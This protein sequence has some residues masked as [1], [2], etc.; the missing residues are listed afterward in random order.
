VRLLAGEVDDERQR[1]SVLAGVVASD[2]TGVRWEFIGKPL[3]YPYRLRV[4]AEVDLNPEGVPCVSANCV[5]HGLTVPDATTQVTPH[6]TKWRFAQ[7]QSNF[8]AAHTT[9]KRHEINAGN[10]YRALDL[11]V[12]IAGDTVRTVKAPSGT[13]AT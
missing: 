5:A 2:Q 1:D 9:P 7:D 11:G 8:G 6:L 13:V 4:G 3:V 12:Q 10:R